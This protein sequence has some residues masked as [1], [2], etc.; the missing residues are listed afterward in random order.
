[1]TEKKLRQ[2]FRN[3]SDCY[4]QVTIKGSAELSAE[5]AI[6]EDQFIRIINKILKEISKKNRK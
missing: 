5:L 6:S 2:L 3:N 4:T 1:M